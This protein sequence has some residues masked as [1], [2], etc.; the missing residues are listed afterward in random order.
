MVLLGSLGFFMVAIRVGG[1]GDCHVKAS[2]VESNDLNQPSADT[3]WIVR[4]V[5]T[6]EV[7]K[8]TMT[9]AIH[10]CG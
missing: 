10:L 8:V 1:S 4:S 3:E 5:P 6:P 2:L 7:D 9:W